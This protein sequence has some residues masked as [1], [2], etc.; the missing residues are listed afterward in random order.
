MGQ[1]D[2]LI[3]LL[4]SPLLSKSLSS[5]FPLRQPGQHITTVFVMHTQIPLESEDPKISDTVKDFL[6]EINEEGLWIFHNYIMNTQKSLEEFKQEFLTGQQ[7]DTAK[8]FKVWAEK[9]K[10]FSLGVLIRGWSRKYG[11]SYMP[12]AQAGDQVTES[13][14]AELVEKL[15]PY[16]HKWWQIG[17]ALRMTPDTLDIFHNANSV[18]Q[19][20]EDMLN[21]W[22]KR[23]IEKYD[24]QGQYSVQYF[25]D[26][27]PAT[28]SELQK[29]LR[30]KTV[31]LGNIANTLTLERLIQPAYQAQAQAVNYAPSVSATGH[32][33]TT[34]IGNVPLAN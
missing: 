18:Q 14:Y 29:A 1:A 15:K 20:F 27:S 32:E 25:L 28:M 12:A 30:S 11:A 21:T 26:L 5:S 6:K 2:E 33:T 34:M 7:Y 17:T 19:S 23:R 9:H 22:I 13:D 31:G 3:D 10:G 8:L 4:S 24:T 16:R